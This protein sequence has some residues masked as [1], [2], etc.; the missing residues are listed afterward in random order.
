M[1][2]P[3]THLMTHPMTHPHDL[4]LHVANNMVERGIMTLRLSVPS[5]C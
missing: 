4:P 5:M 3:M 1:T 2:H